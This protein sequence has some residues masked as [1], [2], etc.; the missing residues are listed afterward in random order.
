[1]ANIYYGAVPAAWTDA[2]TLGTFSTGD[3]YYIQNRGNGDL[4]AVESAT[5]PT[6]QSGTYVEPKKVIKYTASSDKLWVKSLGVICNINIS[7]A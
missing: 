4:L 2:S 6:D 1:M 7:E 5:E 3:S